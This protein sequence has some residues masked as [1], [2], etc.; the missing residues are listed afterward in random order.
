M[1]NNRPHHLDV[2]MRHKMDFSRFI[3]PF[4]VGKNQLSSFHRS[5][6]TQHP[7]GRFPE[8]RER[9]GENIVKR[10]ALNQPVFK[11]LCFSLQFLVGKLSDCIAETVDLFKDRNQLLDIAFLF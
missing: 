4:S 3:G 8:N 10:L 6:F 1:Q 5:F 11:L 7:I 2:K 9:L